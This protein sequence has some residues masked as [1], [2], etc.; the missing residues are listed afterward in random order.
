[1][2]AITILQWWLNDGFNDAAM[3]AVMM[4]KHLK[5]S[6]VKVHHR[7]N[8]DRTYHMKSTRGHHPP[9][10]AFSALAYPKYVESLLLYRE[11]LCIWGAETGICKAVAENIGEFQGN[12]GEL[13]E[14]EAMREKYLWTSKNN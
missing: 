6:F 8:S 9:Q 12:P 1:M 14:L 2:A 4:S 7:M 5:L 13:R 11:I 3:A 10:T